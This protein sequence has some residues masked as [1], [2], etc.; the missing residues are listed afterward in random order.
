MINIHWLE[1]ALFRTY[2]HGSKDVRA[3][4]GLLYK[5]NGLSCLQEQGEIAVT[6]AIFN[7]VLLQKCQCIRKAFPMVKLGIDAQVCR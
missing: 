3:I 4:E 7:F 5:L 6:M 2:F 1:L